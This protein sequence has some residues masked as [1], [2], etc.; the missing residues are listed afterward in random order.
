MLICLLIFSLPP[1]PIAMQL[2]YLLENEILSFKI[3]AGII[4]KERFSE[5]FLPIIRTFA[6]LTRSE[7]LTCLPRSAES[8]VLIAIV[9]TK[10]M[11][12]GMATRPVDCLT[13]FHLKNASYVF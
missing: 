9:G 13:I 11:L 5:N 1:M 10:Q 4:C 7:R 8:N 12:T 6:R 3:K 2:S